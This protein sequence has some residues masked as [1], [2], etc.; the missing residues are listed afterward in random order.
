MVFDYVYRAMP[1]NAPGSLTFNEVYSVI[2][3]LLGEMNIIPKDTTVNE[4]NLAKIKM[5]NRD[6]FIPYDPRP[7]VHVYR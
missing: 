3:Y 6:G 5:P 2:A 4:K 7:D 1:F